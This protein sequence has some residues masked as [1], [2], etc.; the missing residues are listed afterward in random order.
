MTDRIHF[1]YRTLQY[2]LVTNQ[3]YC[4]TRHKEPDRVMATST[5]A[6]KS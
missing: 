2:V 5:D 4:F 1:G 3:T 6:L